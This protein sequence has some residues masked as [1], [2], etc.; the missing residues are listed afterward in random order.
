MKD[1]Q[2]QSLVLALEVMKQLMHE[3]PDVYA[4]CEYTAL[5]HIF[6]AGKARNLSLTELANL[7][8]CSAQEAADKMATVRMRGDH[9]Q[10]G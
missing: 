10:E 8:K 4:D 3:T 9:E 2:I 7:L 5:K 1:I 6:N